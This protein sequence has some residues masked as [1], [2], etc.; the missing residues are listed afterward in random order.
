V[1]TYAKLNMQSDDNLA[2]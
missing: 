1:S 2:C